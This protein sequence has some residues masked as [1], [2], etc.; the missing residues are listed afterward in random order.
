MNNNALNRKQTPGSLPNLI[1]DES[2]TRL[3][4]WGNNKY[5]F[6]LAL[7]FII[8]WLAIALDIPVLRP[9]L[10]FIYVAFVPGLLLLIIFRLNQVSLTAKI[11][12]SV[13]LSASFFL[14]FGLVSNAVSLAVGFEKPLATVPLLAVFGVITV[15]LLVIAL[16]RHRR[17][18]FTFGLPSFSI[19]DKLVLVLPMLFPLL[20]VVGTRWMNMSDNNALLITVFLLIIAYVI[21]L[22]LYH[23]HI[24]E[25]IFL[26]VI[27]LISVSLLLVL[28]LRSSDI[29]LAADTDREYY[30]FQETIRHFHWRIWEP[31]IVNSCLSITILPTI[32]HSLVKID[33]S[34]IFKLFAC[35]FFAFAPLGIYLLARRYFAGVFAFL[36]SVF[37]MSQAVFLYT[38]AEVRMNIAAFFIV[39]SLLA[40]FHGELGNRNGR[41]LFI[42]FYF[43]LVL[44]YYSGSYILLFLILIGWIILKIAGAVLNHIESQGKASANSEHGGNAIT[45]KLSDEI[46][47]QL[48][49]T[50]VMLCFCLLLFW[51][52]VIVGITFQYGVSFIRSVYLELGNFFAWS[53]RDPTT[54]QLV[55]QTIV[56]AAI[57]QQI[58]FVIYWVTYSLIAI[59]VIGSVVRFRN[60][61]FFST[62]HEYKRLILERRLAPAFVALALSCSLMAVLVVVLPYVS[63]G[64]EIQRLYIYVT[65][66]LSTF[67]VIGTIMI[68]NIV[69]LKP[70]IVTVFVLAIYFLS[71]AGLV[72]QAFGVP[73]RIIFNPGETT[74]ES[75]MIRSQQ[76]YEAARWLNEHDASDAVAY[77]YIYR[78]DPL[79]IHGGFSAYRIR[80]LEDEDKVSQFRGGYDY[81]FLSKGGR[82]GKET[83]LL[84]DFKFQTDYY[85]LSLKVN[86][87]YGNG[88]SKIMQ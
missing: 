57:P 67:F 73:R 47:A 41:V 35:F 20:A 27:F 45:G 51:S 40:L 77:C 39:L 17:D 72:D 44:S 18:P 76:D 46:T 81:L 78:R 84:D 56:E 28:P 10:G 13:G 32:Y 3:S 59:G 4:G 30:F 85:E 33:P 88:T 87:I 64:Y 9:L 6:Y 16:F 7:L 58:E 80:Y 26:V 49:S 21:F 54:P 69:R 11:L 74:P 61:I 15:A 2:V 63:R 22:A 29:V 55:G 36:A 48:P 43:S 25:S 19:R 86:A 62:I 71:V 75:M 8:T 65:I 5:I 37:Y 68:S 23:R 50:T 31:D 79:L 82:R 70:A 83:L 38:A 52:S 1:Q 60:M 34:V 53:T 66:V 42:L 24:S 14:I 12:L